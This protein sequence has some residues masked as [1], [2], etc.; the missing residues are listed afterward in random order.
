MGHPAFIAGL[1][2]NP[3]LIPRVLTQTLKPS[4][5]AWVTARL[6]PCPDTKHEFFR[7]L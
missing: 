2:R 3:S 5:G 1:P 6:K 7:R 4:P